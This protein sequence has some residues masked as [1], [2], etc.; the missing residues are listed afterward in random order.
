M[1]KYEKLKSSLID[2]A[3]LFKNNVLSMKAHEDDHAG[4]L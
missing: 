4:K 3:Q 2:G 1:E